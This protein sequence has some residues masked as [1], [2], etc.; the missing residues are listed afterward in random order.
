[1]D[2]SPRYGHDHPPAY[3]ATDLPRRSAT[4]VLTPEQLAEV[5]AEGRR[6]HAVNRQKRSRQKHGIDRLSAEVQIEQDIQ[7]AAGECAAAIYLGLPRR[8]GDWYGRWDLG[9]DIEVR[10]AKGQ[11]HRLIVHEDELDQR[12]L[13]LVVGQR[14]VLRL[15]GWIHGHQAKRGEWLH[16]FRSG[17][18]A[19]YVPQ[20][21]LRPM[22]DLLA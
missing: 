11:Y 21:A 5:E 9:A 6:R 18:Q 8:T 10:S 3:L 13:L 19:Y 1:M 2:G 15:A 17:G 12:R 20:R 14:P 4:V 7:G 16:S 22:D